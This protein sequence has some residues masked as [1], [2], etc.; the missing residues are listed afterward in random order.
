MAGSFAAAKYE[1]R[2]ETSARGQM[3][4]CVADFASIAKE[5]KTLSY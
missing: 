3:R 2:G 1:W 4:A 5:L